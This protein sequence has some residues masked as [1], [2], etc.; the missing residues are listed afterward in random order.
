MI[1]AHQSKGHFVFGKPI[2]VQHTIAVSMRFSEMMG[3]PRLPAVRKIVAGRG[4]RSAAGLGTFT[5]IRFP[6]AIGGGF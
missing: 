4:T 2:E 3:A 6:E 1:H 5:F